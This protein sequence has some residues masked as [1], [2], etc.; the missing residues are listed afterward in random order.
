MI[1]KHGL[2]PS[3]TRCFWCGKDIGVALLGRLPTD[4]AEKMFGKDNDSVKRARR[5][6]ETEMEAPRSIVTDLEPCE[7]CEVW[8][9]SS[10]GVF[11]IEAAGDEKDPKPTGSY[12]LVKDAAIKRMLNPGPLLDRVLEK[13]VMMLDTADYSVIFLPESRD[14]AK[15]A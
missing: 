10:E 13:R 8:K 14:S 6:R 3:V 11:V 12:M 1:G 5:N 9:R 7:G 15:E 2:N 4:R